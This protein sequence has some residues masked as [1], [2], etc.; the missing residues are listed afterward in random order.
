MK[1]AKVIT[2]EQ[3]G[4]AYYAGK[5]GVYS[6]HVI[7]GAWDEYGIRIRLTHPLGV[8]FGTLL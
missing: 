3:Q 2:E 4:K 7:G 8:P 5:R 1:I 6:S